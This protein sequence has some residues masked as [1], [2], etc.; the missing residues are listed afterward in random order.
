MLIL[1]ER[2]DNS[3]KLEHQVFSLLSVDRC[4]LMKADFEMC[5][6][7]RHL[8]TLYFRTH[9]QFFCM[10]ATKKTHEHFTH[11]IRSYW[12]AQL[13][14]RRPLPDF[15]L[16]LNRLGLKFV[17]ENHQKC[18]VNVRANNNSYCRP[19][20]MLRFC[21]RHSTWSRAKKNTYNHYFEFIIYDRN[22]QACIIY[23]E[24]NF[25]LRQYL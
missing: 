4:V 5:Q 13:F 10:R 17:K 23:L 21:E 3:R 11:Q 9:T 19:R 18:F 15:I 24:K 22:I 1:F 16:K 14:S 12:C 2:E 20:L 6:F 7:H 25:Q 8:K